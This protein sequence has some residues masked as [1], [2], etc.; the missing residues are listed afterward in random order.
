MNFWLGSSIPIR[1]CVNKNKILLTVFYSLLDSFS[2]TSIP[3]FGPISFVQLSNFSHPFL[4]GSP[5]LVSF[6][7][8][9]A[10]WYG[11]VIIAG[12]STSSELVLG[13][14]V[15]TLFL[16]RGF[17]GVHMGLECL[18]LLGDSQ[19]HSCA[20][21]RLCDSVKLMPVRFSIAYLSL[22]GVFARDCIASAV[23]IWESVSCEWFAAALY[24]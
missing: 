5:Y 7:E 16:S 1:N 10:R 2:C 22:I 11:V 13:I 14:V 12:C 9:V 23:V 19:E 3:F 6:L 20:W 8:V 4:Q 18:Q 21:D 24:P 15:P 17:I